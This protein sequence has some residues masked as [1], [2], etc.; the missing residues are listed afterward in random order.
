MTE[1]QNIKILIAEDESSLRTILKKMFVK[2]GFQVE[3]APD[4][5]I[6][7]AKIRGEDFDVAIVDIKMPERNGF[8][9]LSVAQK[10]KPQLPILMITAQDTMKNAVEAMKQG[11][12]DYITKPFELEELEL[13]VERAL[14]T[15]RLSEEIQELKQEIQSQKF[16]RQ[17]KII[18]QSR[19]IREIYKLIGKV[20]ASDI[21]VL[22]SGESG[23]GKE[24]IAKSIHLSGAR[25]P[26]PFIAVNC[27]AIP[28]D[29]LES[30]LFGYRKGAFTGAEESR[31]GYFEAAHKGTL[32]LDEIGDMP[33]SLQSK[34]LRALQEK[35]ITRLGSTERLS[36]DVRILSATNQDLASLVAKKKFREDLFFRLN[37]V[38]IRVPP[39][40]ERREDIAILSDYFRLRFSQELSLPPK[41]LA[42]DAL[43]LLSEYSWPGNVRELEN[44]IKRSMVM[45]RGG[46]IREKDLENILNENPATL[47]IEEVGEASLEEL[48]QNRLSRFL[49]KF[50]RLE[51]MDLY[52]KITQMVERP[53]LSLVLKKTRGNQ[54]QAARVLGINR[55][56]LRKKIK[57]LKIRTRHDE[58]E[59]E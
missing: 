59:N 15:R 28:K 32:F 39:L 11:A 20:A 22:I 54:I 52:D 8:E 13:I 19:A 30:E 31:P 2:K 53:L 34:L 5:E 9:V 21:P 6:A 26:H 3:T 1:P 45:T 58:Q 41:T 24:L 12:F 44:V 55:N 4:G 23:T 42:K 48:V 51:A 14:E 25:A 10:E 56:T 27:A 29:L 50:D 18:G 47:T 38:P 49:D 17:A 40:R 43:K 35:E 7:L 57:T 33:L 36:V 16:D 37:V 46:A